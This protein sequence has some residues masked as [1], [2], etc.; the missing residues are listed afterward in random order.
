MKDQKSQRD[1]LVLPNGSSSVFTFSHGMHFLHILLKLETGFAED[2]AALLAHLGCQERAF[3]CSALAR[4]KGGMSRRKLRAMWSL[5]GSI[6]SLL[7]LSFGSF[8]LWGGC[9]ME[10]AKHQI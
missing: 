6:G 1:L 4:S 9:E 3:A 8:V 2:T 5:L 10:K 7:N